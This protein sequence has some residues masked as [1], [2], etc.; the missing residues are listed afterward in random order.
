[1]NKKKESE[2]VFYSYASQVKPFR[3]LGNYFIEKV[4]NKLWMCAI[5]K[6][7]ILQKSQFANIPFRKIPIR[8]NPISQKIIKPN[9][10][11]N[12]KNNL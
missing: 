7:P 2:G 9:K 1:M 8:K 3:E 4:I 10:K 6:M 11:E 12:N 5:S